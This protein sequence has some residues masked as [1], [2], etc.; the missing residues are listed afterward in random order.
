MQ[1][2]LIRNLETD[3]SNE[4]PTGVMRAGTIRS[5]PPFKAFDIV[6]LVQMGCA[7]PA[8]EECAKAAN[9]TSDQ[10]AAAQYAYERANR[11]IAPEDFE[12]YDAGLMTGYRP[13]G[14]W[15]PGPN[16]EPEQDESPLYLPEDY[17]R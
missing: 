1:C 4:F 3:A 9:M 15:I 7:E 16:A 5:S 14:S 10:M 2:R 8:D 11:G 6:T 12:A 13:D 17:D